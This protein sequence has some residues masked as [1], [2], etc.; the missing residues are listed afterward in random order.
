MKSLRPYQSASIEAAHMQL[1]QFGST[2][3]VLPTG[4]GKTVVAAKIISD[5]EHGNTLFLAHTKELINQA[6]DKIGIELGYRPAV[7]MGVVG[8]DVDTLWQGGMNV[9]GSVQSMIGDRRLNKY[10]RHPFGLIIV[11]EAHHSTSAS[12]RK[13]IDYFHGLNANLKVIGITATPNRTD[14]A[15]LGMIFESVAYQMSI[16]DAVNGGWLVPVQQEYIVVDSLNFDELKIRKNSFGEADFTAD[17]LEEILTEEETL[18]K[19]ALPTIEKVG[20]RRTLIFTASVEHAHKL[21]AVLNRYRDGCAAAVD[22][23]TPTEMRK[24][25]IGDFNDG[26]VQFLA[27]CAVLTEGFDSPSCSAIV[28]GRPTKSLSLYTQMLGRGLR[29]LPGVVDG[30]A[31]DFDRRMAILTSDKPNCLVLDFV[32]NSEHK[33]ANAYDVLGGNYD[34]EARELARKEAKLERKDI[35][36]VMDQAAALLALERQWKEREAITAKA[37][38]GTYQVDP[39]GDD[40]GPSVNMG[41]APRRG[42]ATDNQVGLL[43]ELGVSQATALSY[44]KRQ[45]GAILDSIMAT[46]CTRRQAKVL[47]RAGISTEGIGFKRASRIID[48]LAKNGWKRPAELPE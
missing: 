10:S 44:S 18:H 27:N 33:L 46:K 12:Y 20:E 6:A 2:V 36:E 9:V 31:D 42:G 43:V 21:A 41:S 24:R 48:A 29:P 34:M 11:D 16:S 17:Q 19:M 45:A 28:M 15:A 1:K 3:I 22:G 8:Q 30:V 13:I 39:F 47:T 7:E 23:G 35:G 5:W 40:S 4:L 25:V 14:G 38:Y 26:R 37:K 32:G